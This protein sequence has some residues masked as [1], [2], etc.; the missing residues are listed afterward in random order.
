MAVAYTLPWLLVRLVLLVKLDVVPAQLNE[1]QNLGENA[2]SKWY[3]S[4][5]LRIQDDPVLKQAYELA[6]TVA[7]A[8]IT[9]AHALVRQAKSL[10]DKT[11][12]Y[13]MRALDIEDPNRIPPMPGRKSKCTEGKDFL[14]ELQM[15]K[16]RW[17]D[18]A[19]VLKESLWQA[20]IDDKL[21]GYMYARS[22]GVATPSVLWCDV[23]GVHALPS[24]FPE[25]WGCCFVLKPLHGYNSI[26]VSIID[27]GVDRFTGWP[28]RGR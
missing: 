28:V 22:I 21:I 23:I 17:M 13:Q 8:N 20:A 12:M 10:T 14:Y 7:Q 19:R 24:L 26:G 15:R 25:S 2:K 9:R 27:H 1:K 18:P 4:V 11:L 16:D 6:A 3:R 5:A